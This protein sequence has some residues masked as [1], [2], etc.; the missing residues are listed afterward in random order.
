[1]QFKTTQ[2]HEFS[3]MRLT[4]IKQFD[5]AL[6]WGGCG[7]TALSYMVDRDVNWYNFYGGRTDTYIYQNYKCP[8]DSTSRNFFLQLYLHAY[9][10][11]CI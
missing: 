4:K 9:K 2:K 8:R 6:S 7:Q 5:K 3:S 11:V 1:M 10:I